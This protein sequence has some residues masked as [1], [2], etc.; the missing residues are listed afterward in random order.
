MIVLAL[1]LST[2]SSGYAIFQD[3]NLIKHG[4]ITAGSPN[5]Y[6]RIHRM[7]DEITTIVE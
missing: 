6:N 2:K 7:A 1:D 5:L 4:C 3:Q